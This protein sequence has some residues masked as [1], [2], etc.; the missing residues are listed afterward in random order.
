MEQERARPGHRPDKSIPPLAEP[1][2]CLLGVDRLEPE[3][4]PLSRRL[5]NGRFLGERGHEWVITH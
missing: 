2:E 1:G 3:W 5:D 4:R